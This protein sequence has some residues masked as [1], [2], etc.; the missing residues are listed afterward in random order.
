[1]SLD[2]PEDGA[3]GGATTGKFIIQTDK[4]THSGS[5]TEGYSIPTDANSTLTNGKSVL[6]F[7]CTLTQIQLN[8]SAG[9]PLG[10]GSF[11]LRRRPDGGSGGSS[12][13]VGAV[14]AFNQ[15]VAGVIEFTDS[16]PFF[17][18]DAIL[19]SIFLPQPTEYWC[20]VVLEYSLV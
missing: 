19:N 9:T 16:I 18:G 11:R 1:M 8:T 15:T 12:T 20:T 13:P 10:N 3:G 6:P 4:I 14:H 7:D 2:N 17:K 5:S